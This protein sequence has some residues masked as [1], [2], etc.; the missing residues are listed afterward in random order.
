MADHQTARQ[1]HE[2]HTKQAS[3]V[4][5]PPFIAP[6]NNNGNFKVHND[7]KYV[8]VQISSIPVRSI[9]VRLIFEN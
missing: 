2:A 5:W 7:F 3:H 4:P 6:Y 1:R 8:N 9:L